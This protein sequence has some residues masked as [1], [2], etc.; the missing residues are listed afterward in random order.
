MLDSRWWAISCLVVLGCRATSPAPG[1]G[2]SLGSPAGERTALRSTFWGERGIRLRSRLVEPWIAALDASEEE[3]AFLRAGGFAANQF[4]IA[5][6]LF[7]SRAGPAGSS[8]SF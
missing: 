7:R 1:G 6:S 8:D 5:T 2:E 3:I 4:A